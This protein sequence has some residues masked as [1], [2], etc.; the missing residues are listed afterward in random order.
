MFEREAVADVCLTLQVVAFV[1]A[2]WDVVVCFIAPGTVCLEAL[3][4]LVELC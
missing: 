2:L 1:L 3:I 4:A